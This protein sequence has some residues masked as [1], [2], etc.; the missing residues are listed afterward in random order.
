MSRTCSSHCRWPK[1][2]LIAAGAYVFSLLTTF[3]P[4]R[5]AADV[6]PAE[7]LRYE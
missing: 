4:A 1:I 5:Q 2:L 7:A 6:S 3:L